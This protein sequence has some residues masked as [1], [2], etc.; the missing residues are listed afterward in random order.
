MVK[1]EK[2]I[3]V[4]IS[5]DLKELLKPTLLQQER[6]RRIFDWEK[7]S[8]KKYFVLGEPSSKYSSK[9]LY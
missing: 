1:K 3:E 7:E 5:G 4:I 9:Q 2:G 6:L 8:N